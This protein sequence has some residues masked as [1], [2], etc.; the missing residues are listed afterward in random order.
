MV[1]AANLAAVNGLP[2]ETDSLMACFYLASI[3]AEIKCFPCPTGNGK[4][5]KSTRSPGY[6]LDGFTQDYSSVSS[7]FFFFIHF[8]LMQCSVRY[9]I[10]RMSHACINNAA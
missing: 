7:F 6:A 3:H 8:V 9:V 5:V 10:R 1:C 4:A 2:N